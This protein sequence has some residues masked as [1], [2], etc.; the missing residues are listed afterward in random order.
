MLGGDLRPISGAV[1]GIL[2]ERWLDELQIEWAFIGSSGLNADGVFTTELSE[3]AIKSSVLRHSRNRILAAD[4]SKWD[5]PAL[6]RFAEWNQFD[7]W[8]TDASLPECVADTINGKPGFKITRG[9][10][11]SEPKGSRGDGQTS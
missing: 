8:L 7:S 9:S 11:H 10:R 3:A 2:A 5:H 6:V 1:T 4:S